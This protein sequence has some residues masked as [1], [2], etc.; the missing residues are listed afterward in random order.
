MRQ[1]REC[2]G[3]ACRTCG[4]REFWKATLHTFFLGWW[5]TISFCVTPVFIVLNILS[6]VR[7]VR[8]PTAEALHREA[9]EAQ[10]DYA[11]NLLRTKDEATVVDVLARSSGA[12]RADVESF[13]YVLTTKPVTAGLERAG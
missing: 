8:L 10:E 12:S 5:G 3:A 7:V 2:A 1:S 9:L 13:V 11:R 4:L 6:V